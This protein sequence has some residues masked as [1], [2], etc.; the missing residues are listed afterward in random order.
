MRRNVEYPYTPFDLNCT[1]A[2]WI[3]APAGMLRMYDIPTRMGSQESLV[4]DARLKVDE[5]TCDAYVFLFSSITST[6]LL[7][8][9]VSVVHKECQKHECV[10]KENSVQY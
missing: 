6:T 4:Y 7:M 2:D 10:K 3:V 8:T 5:T 9:V 1:E